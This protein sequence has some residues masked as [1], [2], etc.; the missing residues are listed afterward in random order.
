[1]LAVHSSTLANNMRINI[2][3]CCEGDNAAL[4]LKIK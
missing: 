4:L 2:L 3:P 1:M